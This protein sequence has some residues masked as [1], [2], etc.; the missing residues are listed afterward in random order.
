MCLVRNGNRGKVCTPL[1]VKFSCYGG[2]Q[3]IITSILN[4]CLNT[5]VLDTR[6]VETQ[7]RR[8]LTFRSRILKKGFL[9]CSGSS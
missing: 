7:T 1:T 6:K 9:Q 3:S 2:F 5:H 4:L 8:P